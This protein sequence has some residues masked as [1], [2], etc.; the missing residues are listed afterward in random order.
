[1]E[2]TSAPLYTRDGVVYV[3][4][5]KNETLYALNAETGVKLWSLLLG[6]K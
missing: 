2:D 1:V 5:L 6:S 3:H 4:T